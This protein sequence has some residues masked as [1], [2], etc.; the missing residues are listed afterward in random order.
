MVPR[1]CPDSIWGHGAYRA[2]NKKWARDGLQS[3]EYE[4]AP[5]CEWASRPHNVQKTK[6]GSAKSDPDFDVQNVGDFVYI[7]PQCVRLQSN[8]PNVSYYLERASGKKAYWYSD[9]F[10]QFKGWKLKE[11]SRDIAAVWSPLR[12]LRPTRWQFDLMNAGIV[13]QGDL[14]VMTERDLSQYAKEHVNNIADDFW[15]LQTTAQSTVRISSTGK[16]WQ[17]PSLNP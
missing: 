15:D 11:K 9:G 12:L 7:N 8:T 14:R 17:T 10:Q 16:A 4:H 1:R 2:I 5:Q 6:R 3:G 13:T